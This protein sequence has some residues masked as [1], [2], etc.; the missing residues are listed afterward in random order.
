MN[1]LQQQMTKMLEG[2]ADLNKNVATKEDMKGVNNRLR[3]IETEQKSLG[4]RL[5]KI[6]R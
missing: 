5:T 1:S 6:E 3:S 4:A 2:M